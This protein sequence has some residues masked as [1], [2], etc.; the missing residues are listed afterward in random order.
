MQARMKA[1]T[2][3]KERGKKTEDAL[4][5]VGESMKALFSGGTA[6][7]LMSGGRPW[8]GE[9]YGGPGGLGGIPQA[10]GTKAAGDAPGAPAAAVPTVATAVAPGQATAAAAS[11]QQHHQALDDAAMRRHCAALERLVEMGV[12][13]QAARVALRHLDSWIV[14]EDGE[15]EMA[16]AEGAAAAAGEPILHVGDRV[17]LEGLVKNSAVN[18]MVGTLLAYSA[19]SIRW[20]VSLSDGQVFWVKPKLLKPLELRRRPLPH[21]GEPSAISIVSG[22]GAIAGGGANST[23]GAAAAGEASSSTAQA[24]ALAAGWAGLEARQ[25][26]WK[27][28]QEAREILLLEREEALR[29]LHQALEAEHHDV[30]DQAMSARTSVAPAPGSASTARTGGAEAAEGFVIAREVGQEPLRVEPS[31]G[32]AAMDASHHE[33]EPGEEDE[34]WDMDWTTM[35]RA[36]VAPSSGSTAPAAVSDAEDGRRLPPKASEVDKAPE[37]KDVPEAKEAPEAKATDAEAKELSVRFPEPQAG[38]AP[39]AKLSPRTDWSASS[40]GSCCAAG[41]SVASTATGAAGML[42]APAAARLGGGCS[43]GKSSS[44]ES[45][46]T[47]S[48]AAAAHASGDGLEMDPAERRRLAEKLEEK[49]RLADEHNGED[50]LRAPTREFNKGRMPGVHPDVA[51]KL[52]E[53]RRKLEMEEQVQ[54]TS[55]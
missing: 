26:V 8:W 5:Q 14:G 38:E 28:E 19:D 20:K 55:A 42:K 25:A 49:R 7:D 23:N 4:H 43:S 18:G 17:R 30:G 51:Q 35:S 27:E 15:A 31:D 47:S 6:A 11:V 50:H 52:E 24:A 2:F 21:S 36:A 22:G 16:A 9:G 39:E 37:A 34:M 32:D 40:T 45:S 41:G 46:R 12:S 3:F 53:R 29:K 10:A 33:E 48:P 54:T 1:E 44:P 13:P